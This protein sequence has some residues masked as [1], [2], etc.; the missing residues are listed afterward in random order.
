MS[1]NENENL[2]AKEEE[3]SKEIDPTDENSVTEM[4]TFE[5]FLL[6]MK[7]GLNMRKNSNSF[8]QKMRFIF[9]GIDLDG[10][11]YISS[12]DADYLLLCYYKNDSFSIAKM[13]FCGADK[14][15]DR[16]ISISEIS[17]AISNLCGSKLAK[18]QF[19][20]KCQSEFGQK[21]KE[22]KFSEFYKVLTDQVIDENYDPYEGRIREKSSCCLLI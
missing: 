20:S 22:L 3:S 1:N 9:D 7:A 2:S 17:N 10:T 14:N 15:R 16:K 21:V 19:E 11:S 12:R 8:N 18:E 13:F 6:Y 4:L 5:K